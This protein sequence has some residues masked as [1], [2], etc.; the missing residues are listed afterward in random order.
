MNVDRGIDAASRRA[1]LRLA[2]DAIAAEASRRDPGG[3]SRTVS[4]AATAPSLAIFERRRGAFV[5]LTERSRLRGCIGRVKTDE[6]LRSLI[7]EVA[8]LAAFADPRFSPM[9]A[10]E[11]PIVVLEISLLSPP[12]AIVDT[13]DVVVGRHG[14]QIENR[15]R[16]GL[17]LPQVAVEYGWSREEFLEEV[18]AK[19][20]LP[21]GAWREASARIESFTADVF[22]EKDEAR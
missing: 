10:A 3:A 14:L 13:S 16:R 9:R 15:G 21:R 20:G 11:L 1:L 7:P 2:R 12:V 8:C 5:T 4:P 19:A 17:L 6:P 22:S 18:C